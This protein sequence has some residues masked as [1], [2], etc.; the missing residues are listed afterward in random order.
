MQYHDI[1]EAQKAIA[2]PDGVDMTLGGRELKVEERTGQT[3]GERK[4]SGKKDNGK[5][6]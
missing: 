4:K 3:P 1:A 6:I 2:N 5:K